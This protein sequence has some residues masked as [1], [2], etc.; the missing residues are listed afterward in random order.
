MA[1]TDERQG[2]TC[3][4]CGEPWSAWRDEEWKLH[5]MRDDR[6][7]PNCVARLRAEVERLSTTAEM[8]STWIHENCG[9][10]LE[11]LWITNEQID[12]AWAIATGP[13]PDALDSLAELSIVAC[14]ECG[15]DG[16]WAMTGI[17]KSC[18]VCAK[19]TGHGWIKEE[20]GDE[21]G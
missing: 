18:P 10:S 21:H 14:K 2:Q 8:Q 6:G 20:H 15:G 7:I 12:A 9:S 19:Y 1:M 16:V 17:N 13:E 4:H 3:D 11:G 5:G